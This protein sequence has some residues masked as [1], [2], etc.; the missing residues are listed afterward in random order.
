[1]TLYRI[2]GA[3]FI[4]NMLIMDLCDNRVNNSTYLQLMSISDMNRL[5]DSLSIIIHHEQYEF[6]R[7]MF[8]DASKIMP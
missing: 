8:C 4:E 6:Q 5:H 3:A 2:M 1:M 7:S